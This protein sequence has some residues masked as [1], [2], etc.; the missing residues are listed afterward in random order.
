MTRSLVI[1]ILVFGAFLAWPTTASAQAAKVVNGYDRANETT[2]KGSVVSVV[3][4][5]GAADVVGLH[6]DVKT[7]RGIVKVHVAPALFV[8]E[9]NFWFECDEQIEVTGATVTH[10]GVTALWARSIVKADKTLAVRDEN[11]IPL[12][13]VESGSDPDGCGVSHPPNR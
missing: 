7:D 4:A 2:I 8:G 1:P 11:G 9:H 13:K 3:G 6:L 12:W 5:H 10:A